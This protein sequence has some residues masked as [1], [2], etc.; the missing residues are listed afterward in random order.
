M[1]PHALA[2]AGSLGLRGPFRWTDE[3]TMH[4][5][6]TLAAIAATAA[7][8]GCSSNGDNIFRNDFFE[9]QARG[10]TATYD[11]TARE[12]T[13]DRSVGGE[14]TVTTATP[15]AQPAEVD[16]RLDS[17]GNLAGVVVDGTTIFAAFDDTI[18]GTDVDVDGRYWTFDRQDLGAEQ[19]VQVGNPAAQQLSYHTYGAWVELFDASEPE[20]TIGAAAFGDPVTASL[21]VPSSGSATYEGRTAGFYINEASDLVLATRSTMTANANFTFDTIGFRTEDTVVS[22]DVNGSFSTLRTS[23]NTEGTLLIAGNTFSGD[24][25]S[26]GG[27][28]GDASGRFF[29]PEAEEMGGTLYVS[30]GDEAYMAGFGG[31]R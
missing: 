16:I 23:L 19:V 25:E 7:L 3:D 31:R 13:F 24:V 27:L 30:D 9:R 11:G 14:L 21:D 28:T 18:G 20:G 5:L 29:G 17:L 1:V 26:A 15:A 10:T 4:R 8:A 6:I 22:D 12:T 2:V